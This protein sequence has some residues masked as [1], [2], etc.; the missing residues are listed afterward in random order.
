[1]QLTHIRARKDLSKNA[2]AFSKAAEAARQCA[3][4]I[5]KF[6][7]AAALNQLKR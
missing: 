5:R 4:A 1:M 6:G 7:L 2:E 3:E